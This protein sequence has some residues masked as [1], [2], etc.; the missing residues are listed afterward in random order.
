MNASYYFSVEGAA[1][2]RVIATLW[3]GRTRMQSRRFHFRGVLA[4]RGVRLPAGKYRLSFVCEGS[5]AFRIA[6]RNTATDSVVDVSSSFSPV[7]RG[8]W[9]FIIP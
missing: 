7:S 2:A 8:R 5:G 6:V 1:T 4:S 9:V 3:R